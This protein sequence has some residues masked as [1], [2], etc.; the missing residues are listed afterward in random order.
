MFGERLPFGRGDP[1]S[2]EHEAGVSPPGC[3]G[4]PA[5]VPK[6]PLCAP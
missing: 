6:E 4:A 2:A 3:G 1:A 5:S